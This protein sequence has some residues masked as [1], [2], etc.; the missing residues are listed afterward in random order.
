MGRNIIIHENI[1]EIKYFDDFI[2]ALENV[3][4]EYYVCHEI[5]GANKENRVKRKYMERVFAYEFYHQYRKIMERKA[6]TYYKEGELLY[7]G[8]EQVK[9]SGFGD[10]VQTIIPDLVLHGSFNKD[11]ETH[12]NQEWL[13]EIKTKSNSRK[14]NDL[15]KLV[16]SKVVYLAFEE[17]IFLHI[18]GSWESFQKSLKNWM[19]KHKAEAIDNS[20]VNKIICVLS[21]RTED[22]IEIYASRLEDMLD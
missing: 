1:K 6:G 20:I 17:L 7:L 12:E 19:K 2:K 3:G 21:N 10:K 4:H 16:S 22:Y 5:K 13:C 15:D 14:Y 18:G 9:A 8:G 11:R